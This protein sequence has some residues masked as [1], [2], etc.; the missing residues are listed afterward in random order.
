MGRG[1]K[2]LLAFLK[3]LPFGEETQ[4]GCSEFD[5]IPSEKRTFDDT[6]SRSPRCMGDEMVRN[7]WG[8]G[9]GLGNDLAFHE[10]WSFV[11]GRVEDHDLRV[12]ACMP[13]QWIWL[14]S[15]VNGLRMP[16]SWWIRSSAS[17]WFQPAMS[18]SCPAGSRN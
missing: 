9:G 4:M 12:T 2:P 18:W 10:E 13:G 14:P 11:S 16:G 1:F 5:D 8:R 15:H 17:S 7:L 3:S 6:Q